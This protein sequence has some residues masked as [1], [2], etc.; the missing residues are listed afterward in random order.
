MDH[1]RA[2]VSLRSVGQRDPL[3]EFK[4]EAFTLFHEFSQTL[5]TDIALD[6]FKFE[7][8][9]QPNPNLQQLLSTLQL[10]TTR[11]FLEDMESKR[12]Q[13]TGA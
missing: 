8:R 9:M 11:S 5:R 13:E 12:K 10:E 2:E 3:T 7:I 1:L 6:L 4:H